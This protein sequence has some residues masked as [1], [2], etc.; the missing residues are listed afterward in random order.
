[1]AKPLIEDPHSASQ[2]HATAI[3]L[4]GKEANRWEEQ[5]CLGE[6]EDAQISYGLLPSSDA[7]HERLG[8]FISNAFR[9]SK[10][11]AQKQQTLPTSLTITAH[12]ETLAAPLRLFSLRYCYRLHEG[13][14]IGIN[15]PSRFGV[16]DG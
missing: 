16:V 3:E 7:F 13:P 1:M 10:G 5:F 15:A 9:D 11:L 4:I 6:D 8:R 2:V 14:S 12:S